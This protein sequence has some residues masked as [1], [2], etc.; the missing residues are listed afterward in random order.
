MNLAGKIDHTL[1]KAEAT[2]DEI[3]H[4]VAEAVEHR[5]AS[6]CVNG[7]Y[8]AEVARG[9][10]GSGVKACA[11]VG[12]PLGANKS[13]VKAIEATVAVKDGAQE[14]DF[15]AHLQALLACDLGAARTEFLEI[16]KAARSVNPRVIIK[17][18]IESALLLKDSDRGRGEARIE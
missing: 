4:L 9:L 1:L 5:F 14:I 8:V 7:V 18:I 10:R 2:Q 3:R 13:T 17:V 15:A 16:V 6:V 11:V 12:F